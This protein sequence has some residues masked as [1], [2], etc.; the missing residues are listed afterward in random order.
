[1]H[2]EKYGQGKSWC[3]KVKGKGLLLGA[4]MGENRFAQKWEQGMGMLQKGEQA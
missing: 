2:R 4:G 3:G 1:M